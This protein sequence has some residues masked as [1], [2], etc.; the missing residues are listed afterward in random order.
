MTRGCSGIRTPGRRVTCNPQSWV[1]YL[2]HS[3]IEVVLLTYKK[4]PWNSVSTMSV[5]Y[6]SYNQWFTPN[7]TWLHTGTTLAIVVNVRPSDLSL[8]YRGPNMAIIWCRS[9]QRACSIVTRLDYMWRVPRAVPRLYS[10]TFDSFDVVLPLSK[11][12][13]NEWTDSWKY[14]W[15]YSWVLI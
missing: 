12:N 3:A 1:R 15:N 13:I 5:H 10:H 11:T 9:P 8:D 2:N 4:G 6:S 7:A 14:T